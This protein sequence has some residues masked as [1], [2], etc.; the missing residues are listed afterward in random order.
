MVVSI[1]DDDESVRL[2]TT[3]LVRSLGY[4]V[5]AYSSAEEFLDS[6]R[7]RDVGCVISDVRMPGMDGIQMQRRLIE[8]N[9]ALPIIFT[10]A[11]GTEAMRIQAMAN[12]ALCFLDKPVSGSTILT[13]LERLGDSNRE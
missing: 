8:M 9:V 7:F 4:E 6:G 5:R 2:A 13:W 3:S 10:S 11:F 12:G 1:V